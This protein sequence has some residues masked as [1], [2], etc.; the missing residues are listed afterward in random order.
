VAIATPTAADRDARG[1]RS[2]GGARSASPWHSASR[3]RWPPVRWPW[4]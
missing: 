2:D 4:S 1:G 3:L